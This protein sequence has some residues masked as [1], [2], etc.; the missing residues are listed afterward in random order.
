MFAC[1]QSCEFFSQCHQN[2]NPLS[3]KRPRMVVS[4]KRIWKILTVKLN[5]VKN[6]RNSKTS[7]IRKFLKSE[8]DAG[9]EPATVGLKVQRSTDWANQASNTGSQILRFQNK[10]TLTTNFRLNSAFALL[11]DKEDTIRHVLSS[12]IGYWNPV[13]WLGTSLKRKKDFTM[14]SFWKIWK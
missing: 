7:E 3:R 11:S 14:E 10:L 13:L 6:F 9:L 8:P 5:K 4:K 2:L 12:L 1:W